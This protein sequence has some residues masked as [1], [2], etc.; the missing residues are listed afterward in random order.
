MTPLENQEGTGN[1]YRE[2]FA[3]DAPRCLTLDFRSGVDQAAGPFDAG[4][5]TQVP[6]QQP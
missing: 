6:G 1:D 2:R 4:E 5:L 3:D